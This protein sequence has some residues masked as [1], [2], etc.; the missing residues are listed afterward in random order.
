METRAILLIFLY[1]WSVC[2]KNTSK[3]QKKTA[4]SLNVLS[5]DNFEAVLAIF[6]SYDY[7]ATASEGV[8]KI[9]TD[10]KDCHKCSVCM[11]V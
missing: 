1:F 9:V 7:C 8:E 5:G 2:T 10:E 4:F 11:I 6:Y 3:Q